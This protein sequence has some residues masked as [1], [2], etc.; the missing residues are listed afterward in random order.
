[1]KKISALFFA[2]LPILSLF[3]CSGD[4]QEI[5][6][7][8][9]QKTFVDT[10]DYSLRYEAINHNELMSLVSRKMNFVLLVVDHES[11]C[12]CY[13]S[14]QEAIEP[15]L[16]KNNALIYSIHPDEFNGGAERLGLD[17]LSG[18]ETVAI[19]KEGELFTQRLTSTTSDPF[20]SNP[21]AVES[22]FEQYVNWGHGR[23]ISLE[24]LN[25][26]YEG[27]NPFTV[28]FL[29]SS[30]PDCTY[31]EDHLL[32]PALEKD[33]NLLY[34]IDTDQEGIRFDQN[35]NYDETLWLAFKEEYGLSENG[36][37]TPSAYYEGYV[38]SLIYVDPNLGSDKRS[39]VI[40][41]MTYLNDEVAEDENGYYIAHSFYSESRFLSNEWL[42]DEEEPLEGKRLEEKEVQNIGDSLLWQ[43]DSA[44]VYHDVYAQ[45][46]L[47]FYVPLIG[48]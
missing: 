21:E 19:F 16:K 11:T 4:T 10:E 33:R 26:L 40:A 31:F 12:T 27:T 1:M 20:T 3:S 35:G 41:G 39:A 18:V 38:P 8:P 42:S 32:I 48:E 45:K 14:F 22:W 5:I 7:M 34:L 23:Y 28:A 9:Y 17:I 44:S 46:F 24:E 47:D 13:F 2:F 30:C 29:R 37:D 15:Y 43:R 25:A 6:T 36:D